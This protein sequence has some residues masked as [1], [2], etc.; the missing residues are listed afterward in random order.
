MPHF[1]QTRL[2]QTSVALEQHYFRDSN[3]FNDAL[4]IMLPA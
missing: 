2:E 4:P 1:I 3:E